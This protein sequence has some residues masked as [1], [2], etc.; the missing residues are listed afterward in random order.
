MT[1][2]RQLADFICQ[3]PI[4]ER[5]REAAAILLLDAAVNL[6]AGTGTAPGRKI[7]AW[8]RKQSAQRTIAALDAG[9]RAFV[10][11]SLCHIIEMDDLHRASV[12]H[13]GCVVAPVCFALPAGS[14]NTAADAMIRGL[15][16]ATRIGAA[17]GAAHYRIWHNTAT[18]GPFGAAMAGA[19]ILNLDAEGMVNALGNAGTQSSGLWEFNATGAE[20][21]HLHA[22]HAAASGLLAAELALEGFTGAPAILEGERG[23][24]R[25]MCPDG[26]PARVMADR[27]APWQVHRTSLKPWPSC[28]HTHPP[29]AAAL[30]A[31]D[32]L[33]RQS[34]T[35]DDI[36]AVRVFTYPAA[37]ALCDRPAPAS[38]YDAK[39]SLQHSVA[40][41]LLE[42]SPGLNSFDAS[43]RR[44][45]ERL[46]ARIR[47]EA[48]ASL[49]SNYPESWQCRIDIVLAGGATLSK[50]ADGAPGDPEIPLSRKQL[51]EKCVSLL[52]H[53]DHR[54]PEAFIARFL[55]NADRPL[56]DIAAE[57]DMLSG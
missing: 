19:S 32:A 36:E 8:A 6:L 10:F 38:E 51:A 35:V 40:I 21:K 57:I 48:D 16:A 2:T 4:D 54:E 27:D 41:A 49:A 44:R 55:A 43:A 45:A 47:C 13:P 1:V 25:A 42:G 5:D 9:R 28:R 52:R 56:P 53:A 39:F 18:C 26:N 12:V 37:L 31:S 24:F 11:G 50:T 46:A 23:F 14:R 22:G 17:V 33:A 29:L 34:R 30:A 20:S 3:R 15:E 7:L